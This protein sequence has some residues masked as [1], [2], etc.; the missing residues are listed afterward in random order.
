MTTGP[1]LVRYDKATKAPIPLDAVYILDYKGGR[2][3]ASLPTFRQSTGSTTIIE[4]FVE[5]DLAADFKV[6]LDTRPA[7]PLSHDHRIARPVHGRLGS[8]L[9]HR[10]HEQA[11]RG[12]PAAHPGDDRQVVPPEVRAGADAALRESDCGRNGGPVR[13]TSGARDSSAGGGWLDR[14]RRTAAAPA[15]RRPAAAAAG[16]CLPAAAFGGVLHHRP[17][18]SPCRRAWHRSDQSSHSAL[19]SK[20]FTRPP[21]PYVRY[22]SRCP[23][24]CS[25]KRLPSRTGR[26]PA[27]DGRDP[28]QRAVWICNRP[29]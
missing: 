24:P 13:R 27:T 9:R 21:C 23:C 26:S 29:R 15:W 10:D 11:D 14:S 12:L 1:V 22:G 19:G 25:K 20:T 18:T 5:R 8:A 6:D 3:L 7:P 4:S 2:L 16:R 17:A 28:A